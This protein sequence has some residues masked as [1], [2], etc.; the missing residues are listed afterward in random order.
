MDLPLGKLNN[1]YYI[2]LCVLY[3]AHAPVIVG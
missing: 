1:N 3:G 2:Y